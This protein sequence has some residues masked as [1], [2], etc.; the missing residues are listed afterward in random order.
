L[1][2]GLRGPFKEKAMTTT[3]TMTTQTGRQ[4]ARERSLVRELRNARPQRDPR[5]LDAEIARAQRRV[6]RLR[7]ELDDAQ[8]DLI[9]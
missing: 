1:L 3:T 9:N 4:I 7:A 2:T 8:L 5:R 6:A